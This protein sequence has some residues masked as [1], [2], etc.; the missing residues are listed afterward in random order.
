MDNYRLT[1]SDRDTGTR[2]QRMRSVVTLCT[3]VGFAFILLTSCVS[4]ASTKGTT[5]LPLSTPGDRSPTPQLT[6]QYE[7]T[8]QDSGRTVTYTITS[9][10]GITLNSQKYPKNNI[11]VSCQ[12]QDTIGSIS[13]IPSVAPPLYAVRYQGVIAGLCTIRNGT[14][15]LMVRIID[16]HR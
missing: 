5:Q 10:F 16:V 15:F 12:P 13:N 1:S 6:Q 2:Q 7:F 4:P 3:L 8:E 11:Q 9:R 14:F